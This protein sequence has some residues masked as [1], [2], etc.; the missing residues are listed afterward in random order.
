MNIYVTKKK[1][2]ARNA[3]EWV[4]YLP[5]FLLA[6]RTFGARAVI[7]RHNN[8]SDVCEPVLWTM[9]KGS[10]KAQGAAFTVRNI[11]PSKQE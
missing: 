1:V 9:Q 7:E 10:C 2:A 11:C 4:Y 3:D 8:R 5:Y 6:Q